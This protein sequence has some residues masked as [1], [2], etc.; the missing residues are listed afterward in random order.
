MSNLPLPL[1][2]IECDLRDFA[3]MPLDVQRLRDS[4]LA[5]LESPEACWA[6]VLLWCVSWHQVPAASLPNDERMLASFAGYFN[7]GKVDKAWNSVREGA[8]RNWILC[9]DNRYYHPVVADKAMAAWQ[10][11]WEQAYKTE[12]ARIKKHNQR[13]EDNQLEYPTLEQF[14]STRTRPDSPTDIVGLSR[15]QTANVPGK[16]HPTDT[17][18]EGI[19]KG[20]IKPSLD[21]T[22]PETHDT[23]GASSPTPAQKLNGYG[24]IAVQLI[25]LGIQVTSMHPTLQAWVDEGFT[26]EQM[27]EAVGIARQNK[28][29][30]EKIPANYLDRILRD[31]PKEQKPKQVAWY[32]TEKGILAKGAELGMQPRVGEGWPEFK[33]RIND[34]LHEQGR[35]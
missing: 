6:A 10:S 32:A 23:P 29:A 15:G 33:Q 25:E 17:D 1:T 26:M 30:P 14:M 21:D 19:L 5:T 34:K 12:L 2:P 7:R 11:K 4:E 9:S 31:K 16:S 24:P 20:D 18:T 35:T 3:F 28:P 22:S 13:H 27:R 8:M